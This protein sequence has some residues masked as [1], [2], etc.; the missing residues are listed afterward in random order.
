MSVALFFFLFRYPAVYRGFLKPPVGADLKTRKLPAL[1]V[2]IDSDGLHPQVLGDLLNREDNVFWHTS[3]TLS[4]LRRRCLKIDT[5]YTLLIQTN[6]P[7]FTVT[8]SIP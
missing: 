8:L 5:S 6:T 2:L 3:T 1:C 7:W 4:I